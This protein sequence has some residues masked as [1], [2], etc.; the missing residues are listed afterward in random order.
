[1][2]TWEALAALNNQSAQVI[3]PS[4]LSCVSRVS[5]KLAPITAPFTSLPP[6]AACGDI[7]PRC[8]M[9]AWLAANRGDKQELC[10]ELDSGADME[11][12]DPMGRTALMEAAKHDIGTLGAACTEHTAGLLIQLALHP[13]PRLQSSQCVATGDLAPADMAQPAGSGIHCTQSQ[14]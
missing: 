5:S 1:M 4:K 13:H 2:R 9:S 10:R 14:C 8:H 11:F 3:N 12:R 6:I 7:R